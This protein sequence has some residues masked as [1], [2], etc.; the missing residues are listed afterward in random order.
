MKDLESLSDLMN[1]DSVCSPGE[2]N[3]LIVNKM[4]FNTPVPIDQL[5]LVN[6]KLTFD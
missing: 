3:H 1:S 5:F 2:I 6:M 4:N